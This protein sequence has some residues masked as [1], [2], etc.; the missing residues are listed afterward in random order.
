MSV[1]G[2]LLLLLI[3]VLSLCGATE[4]YVRPTEPTNTSCPAQ[5]CLTLSQYVNESDYFF[6]SNT[7]FK[8]LPG[9]HHMDMPVTIGNVHNVLLENV[10]DGHPHLVAQFSCETG[11]HINCL[12]TDRRIPYVCCAAI[13]LHDMS[14]VTFKGLSVTIQS[15]KS[16]AV[17]LKNVSKSSISLAATCSLMDSTCLGILL[18]DTNSIG[19][20]SSSASNCSHG[21]VLYNATNTNITSMYAA[22]GEDG[23]V[24]LWSTDTFITNTTAAHNRGYGMY[25]GNMNKN[26]H[27]F[28]TTAKHNGND[29]MHIYT[30]NN[31]HITDTIATRNYRY[32][33]HLHTL[34]STHITNTMATHNHGDGLYLV[35]MKNTHIINTTALHNR[36]RGIHATLTNITY[37]TNVTAAHNAAD[38]LSL[39]E[40]SNTHIIDTTAKKNTV[41]GLFLHNAKNTHIINITASNNDCQGMHIS[42]TN[43]TI[44]TNAIA[45]HNGRLGVYLEK[46]NSTHITNLTLMHNYDGGIGSDVLV[47]G[48]SEISSHFSTYTLISNSSFTDISTSSSAS[49]TIP[50]SLPAV[51]ELYHS[52]LRFS[53]CQFIRNNVSAVRAYASNIT[54]FGDLIFSDNRATA[55]TAFV[56]LHNSIISLPESSYVYFSDNHATNTGGVFY[57]ASE[58]YLGGN[59]VKQHICFLKREERESQREGRKPQ[60]RFTFANNSAGKG[61]DILYGGYVGYSLDNGWN[62]LDS[63][64]TISNISQSGLSLISSDQSRTCFC[65][66][67]GHPDCLVLA[68]PTTHIIYPGQTLTISAVAVGQDFGTVAGSVYAQFLSSS[69]PK[70]TLQMESWQKVQ[71]VTQNSCNHLDYTIFSQSEGSEVVLVLTAQD[72]YVADIFTNKETESSIHEWE[73]TYRT[74]EPIPLMYINIPVYVNISILPCPPGFMLTT[75]P[76]F[77]CACNLQLRQMHGIKCH[78]QDQ[79]ITRSGLVWVGMIHDDSGTNG[80]IAA[81]EYCPLDY[82]SKGENNVTLSEPDSQC[83]YNHSG[84][85]CGGCQPGLSLALGSAQC[86]PCSN[87]YLALLLPFAL[88]GPMLVFFIKILDLTISQGTMN[89]LIFYAN[90]VKANEYILLPQG[91]INPLTVFIAWLNLDLGVETCFFQGLS[92]YSK[93]WLQFVFPF[94]VWSIAGLIIILAKYSDRVARM[95]GNNSVPVLATLFLLSYAK[96]FRTIITALSYTMLYSSHGHKAVWSADGNVDYLGP[97]HAPLLAAAVAALLILWF[98]YT[99]ILFLGQWLHRCNSRRI[100]HMMMKIKPFLDAHYGPL[101]DKHRYWFGALLLVRAIILLISALLPATRTHLILLCILVCAVALTYFGQMVYHNP[102]VSAFDSAPFVNLALLAGC[103]STAVGDPAVAAYVLIGILFAQFIGLVLFKIF[104]ILK[105][106]MKCCQKEGEDDW[107]LYEQAALQREMESDS[108]VEGSDSSG[109]IESLPT[110]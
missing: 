40:V 47:N 54:L 37:I 93:T 52:T 86:L 15:S 85:L 34:S 24:I 100:S 55:G 74:Y 107:E 38:G 1:A 21:L 79:I 101:K 70:T 27:V 59:T 80:S 22:Y 106:V 98:P 48:Q 94:Y 17:I 18:Y 41:S 36:E 65:N 2:H 45:A 76:P 102:I 35:N 97:K 103:T 8:F 62:C 108:E 87:K 14:N 72:S 99:L 13:S 5:P 32:G 6:K 96:L 84:T 92:S 53:E 83:N 30:M 16:S 20:H 26:T 25:L 56:L 67:H 57:I 63:F 78:I 10:Y 39:E 58:V 12:S 75:H 3:P 9:T 42:W 46:A 71:T 89:G 64:K 49:T 4:Y 95:M 90:V 73:V 109:S 7:V 50:N 105:S 82:C 69:F 11:R 43:N 31:T 60:T 44:I 28:N 23:I 110:Y 51:V 77:R 29:G 33:I 81:S 91:Q 104:S 61:G 19:L 88:A 68:D 66:E